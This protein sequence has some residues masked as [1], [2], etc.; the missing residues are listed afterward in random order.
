M[1]WPETGLNRRRRPFQRHRHPNGHAQRYGERFRGGRRCLVCVGNRQH[2]F[3]FQHAH[4]R[5]PRLSRRA[6]RERDAGRAHK[7]N[8]LLFPPSGHDHWRNLLRRHSELYG[9]LRRFHRQPTRSGRTENRPARAF[10]IMS[11]H[12]DHCGLNGSW[13]NQIPIKRPNVRR[14]LGDP[15]RPL[16]NLLCPYPAEG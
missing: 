1:W 6:K 4:G 12:I 7:R 8:H 14:I 15:A 9:Q 16:V 3:R 2:S 13:P 5:A 10:C 11:P